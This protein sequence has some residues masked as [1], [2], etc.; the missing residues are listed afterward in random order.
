MPC[1]DLG[2]TQNPLKQN[3]W[4]WGPSI[5][6]FP[7]SPGGPCTHDI[8]RCYCPMIYWSVSGRR[9]L[10]RTSPV[11]LA[12]FYVKAEG[13][14]QST[15]PER[16]RQMRSV[17]TSVLASRAKR[18][19]FWVLWRWCGQCFVLLLRGFHA[20]FLLKKADGWLMLSQFYP[21][22]KMTLSG[23]EMKFRARGGWPLELSARNANKI[24]SLTVGDSERRDDG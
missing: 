16:P 21:W 23:P 14:T 22:K 18:S 7:S 12:S 9:Q 24:K 17:P 19:E 13:D 2:T 6:I 8:L 1:V 3:L 15:P 20:S 10:L 11:L 4:G 5:F